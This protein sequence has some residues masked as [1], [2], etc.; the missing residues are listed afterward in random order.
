MGQY[1]IV[2]KPMASKDIQKI[3]IV[4][5]KR[6]IKKLKFFMHQGKPLDYAVK[7]VGE[8]E[9][10]YRWRVGTYRVVFDVDKDAIVILRVQHR[11]EIYRHD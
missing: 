10:H 5:Q 2:F 1:R 3:D 11:R 9:A 8:G 6:I 7:L 4:S